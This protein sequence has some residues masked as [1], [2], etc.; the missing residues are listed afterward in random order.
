LNNIIVD[1][2]R[3]KITISKLKKTIHLKKNNIIVDDGG[4]EYNFQILKKNLFFDEY[5]SRQ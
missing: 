3:K 5:H 2:G 1:E 4:G